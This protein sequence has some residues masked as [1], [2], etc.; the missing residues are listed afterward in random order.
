VHDTYRDIFRST[1]VLAR[2]WVAAIA[3]G[4]TT[5]EPSF[6]DG[7]AAQRVVAA[8]QLSAAAGRRVLIAEIDRALDDR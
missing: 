4:S 2:G 6:D 3:A 1:D 8:C 5:V 7:A